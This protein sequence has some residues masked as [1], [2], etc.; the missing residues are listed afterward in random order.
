[1]RL[2]LIVNTM[3]SAALRYGAITINNPSIWRPILGI[4]DAI[5]AY[6]RAIEAHETISGIFNI[7]SGN[8]RSA[9]LEIS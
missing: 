2:D 5:S 6:T 3:F 9:K 8:Y 1:M 4:E 7:A